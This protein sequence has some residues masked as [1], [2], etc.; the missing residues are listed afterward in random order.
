MSADVDASK[1]YYERHG[2]LIYTALRPVITMRRPPDPLSRRRWRLR[3]SCGANCIEGAE[4]VVL[5]VA[6]GWFRA[7]SLSLVWHES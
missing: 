1:K 5:T 6:T 4:F 2:E 3:L 7:A